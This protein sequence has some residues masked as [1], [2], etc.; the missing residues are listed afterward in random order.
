MFQNELLS[1]C[2]CVGGCA[3]G[4]VETVWHTGKVVDQALLEEEADDVVHAVVL[5]LGGGGAV[6]AGGGR[7]RL[8][9]GADDTHHRLQAERG[10]E[11]T[12]QTVT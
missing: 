1:V 9:D 3:P 8:H 2:V 7:A 12:P 4:K 6:E 5:G 11:P 10:R